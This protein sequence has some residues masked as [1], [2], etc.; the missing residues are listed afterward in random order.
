MGVAEFKKSP[1]AY[2]WAAGV[3]A[4]L[5]HLLPH[6]CVHTTCFNGVSLLCLQCSLFCVSWCFGASG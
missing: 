1:L 6:G 3:A 4:V 2:V 5:F